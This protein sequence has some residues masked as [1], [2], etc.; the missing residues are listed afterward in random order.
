MSII[1]I[2][3]YLSRQEY[4]C[5]CCQQLPP[6]LN[7]GEPYPEAYNILFDIFAIV[8]G[9]WGKGIRIGPPDGGGGYRCPENNLEI[10]GSLVSV[11]PFGL[12]LDGDTNNAE[13]TY[14]LAELIEKVA[15]EVRMG[16]YVNQ[17]TF[18]HFDVGWLIKP[19]LSLKWR[20][21]ARWYG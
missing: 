18:V 2:A 19:R 16:V 1:M 20:E 9:Q 6:D 13:E 17:G 11:H 14:K 8:R 7:N 15:P 3:P 10:G 5:P 4:Q 12:A 21:G